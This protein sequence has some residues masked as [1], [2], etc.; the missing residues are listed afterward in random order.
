MA[1]HSHELEP[2]GEDLEAID[3]DGDDAGRAPARDRD[4]FGTDDGDDPD[5]RR[6]SRRRRWAVAIVAV[7]V[8]ASAAVVAI[9][10]RHDDK[11]R[12]VTLAVPTTGA[13]TPPV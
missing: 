8:A 3:L 2:E 7:V 1:R 6:W 9:A 4:Q 12:D 10:N 11:A 5:E 13:N